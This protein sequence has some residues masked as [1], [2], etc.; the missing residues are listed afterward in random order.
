MNKRSKSKT[1]AKRVAGF[2]FSLAA[3]SPD[4]Q[5]LAAAT[6]GDPF[7]ILGRHALGEREV[8]RCFLPRTRAAWI[9]DE[10]RPMQ[11]LPG[12]D[13]FEYHADAGDVPP[14]YRVIREPDHGGRHG[15]HDPYSFWPQLQAEAM[16]AFH[17]GQHRYAH[18]L[19]GARRSIVNEVEGTLFAV[20]APNAG[21]VSV[22]GDFN[23]W[24]GRC[25][26]MR[27]HAGQ[28]I[29]ELFI[30]GLLDG[31][32]K[33][34]IR[35][36]A[37]G[38]LHIKADPYARASEYRPGT[39][40]LVTGPALHGWED[41]DWEQ[42]KAAGGWHA[43]PMSVYEV[44]LGSWRRNE[45]GSFMGYRRL[46]HEL[47]SYVKHLGFT[48]IEIMPVME[49]PLD[50]SWGYQATGYFAPTSRFGSPD[51]FRYFVDHFHRNGIGVLLDWVPAHFPRDDHALAA[52]DGTALYE[53]HEPI[54]AGHPD[55]GTLVFNF[56][57]NEV[58]SFLVSS[59]MYWLKEFHLDGIRVDAVASMLYLSFS[60]AE[61][62][63]LPNRYGGSENIEAIDFLRQLNEAVG[64]ECPGC[65]MSAEESSAWP[66]VTHPTTHG[67][68]GFGLKWNMGW[69]HDTLDYFSK[70][71]VHR[72]Y[73]QDLLTFG[74]LYAY[75]ENFML[76]LSHDEVVHLKK[77]LF[78]KMP[79][80][81]WQKFANLRLLFTYQWTYPGKELLFMGGEFA[82]QGEW[83]SGT[84]LQWERCHEPMPAGI[85]TL[86]GDLNRMQAAHPALYEWDCD[87]RGFEWLSGEDREQSVIAFLRRG[88]K[89]T[90]AV[91]LNFT[92]VPRHDYRVPAPPGAWREIFNSDAGHYGGSGLLNRADIRSEPYHFAGREH[93]LVV[94]LP[95]LGGVVLLSL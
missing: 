83:N 77:S 18:D 95:P 31:R 94:T 27:R 34:E 90:V 81:E 58:R 86:L 7:A 89:E 52:F 62:Q 17:S 33:F 45:D 84:A 16:D 88:K 22:I 64:Q 78:G 4:C 2:P 59:A 40:S 42:S 26:P 43:R 37:T 21:R 50:E 53:Y 10:S 70:E 8:F 74:P 35:N 3:D 54:K 24:D 5:A 73:H 55:W 57:R 66:G 87:S 13:L 49:H 15:F 1:P 93:S 36:A 14:N 11:R 68:L 48:H 76:P 20:W 92:P 65:V 85:S 29:W 32:Y 19:L 38:A 56:E 91:I 30:P 67:G 63:W 82:Q 44:H 72:K 79:G 6:H 60:R 28:G 75:D 47:C 23:G 9:E 41:E 80:D 25:H 51:D 61:G 46:A 69:M 39:A 71:A 12:T